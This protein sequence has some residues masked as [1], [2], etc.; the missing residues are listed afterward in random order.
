MEK[1]T[2]EESMEWVEQIGK[3]GIH[4]GLERMEALVKA[5]GHPEEKLKI[6]H[7][8]G[9]NGKGSVCT[10]IASV[11]E[12]MGYKVGRYISPTLY[13]YRERIQINGEYIEKTALADGMSRLRE[14]C[15]RMVAEGDGMPTVFEVETAL[16]FWYFK[17]KKCDY[18]VLE[19]GMGG[20]LD[21][22]NVIRHPVLTVITSISMDHMDQL[23]N[24]LEAI[25]LEKA[26]ILKEGAPAVIYPQK[27]EVMSVVEKVCQEK[28]IFVNDVDL[29]Q[30][31]IRGCDFC[32][33]ENV[34]IVEQKF[35]YKSYKNL[36]IHLA[37][38]YQVPNACLAIEALEALDLK[39]PLNEALYQGMEK[40]E[41]PGRFQCLAKKPLTFIDGAHNPEGAKS[42]RESIEAYFPGRKCISVMGV[43]AD[44][45]YQGILKEMA[46]VSD[47]IIT[48]TPENARGLES[49]LLCQAA[50]NFY[51]EA[52]DGGIAANAVELART[53]AGA[54]GL[55]I[56]FGTL[57]TISTICDIMS[58]MEE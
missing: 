19:T 10:M 57:S 35:D 5:L 56:I 42:L 20:R 8:A 43:F 14:I 27:K 3:T 58:T 31:K 40:A 17:Q 21:S 44:K 46:A 51:R 32:E 9:T 50:R 24:S 2:Y 34:L 41:W 16:S 23:G 28:G 49:S 6:I 11:L 29:S 47:T 38:I 54:D 25:A 12:V 39:N 55:I 48:F 37:G 1:M 33:T 22:T 15:E 26:G 45:D 7:V 52:I 30:V 4:L 18:V 13:D 53:K 36:K